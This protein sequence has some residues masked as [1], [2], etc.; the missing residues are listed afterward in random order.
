MIKVEIAGVKIEFEKYEEFEK[1]AKAFE[2]VLKAKEYIP[3]P[4]IV[5][6]WPYPEPYKPYK[7]WIT[8]EVTTGT[9]STL[10]WTTTTLS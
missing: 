4:Y 8:W 10:P 2:E 6:Y 5:P 1:F 3:Q 7:P 9:S